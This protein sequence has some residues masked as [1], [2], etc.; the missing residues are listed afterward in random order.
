MNAPEQPKP[1]RP[2]GPPTEVLG[3]STPPKLPWWQRRWGVAT[4]G[5]VCLLV[6]I[7]IG[8][9]SSSSSTKSKPAPT[10]AQL[11]AQAEATKARIHQEAVEKAANERARVANEKKEVREKDAEARATARKEREEA[12]QKHREEQKEKEEAARKKQEETKEYSGG[13][14]KNLG[15]I[16]VETPST[17]HWE[18]GSCANANFIVGNNG[19]DSHQ[20]NV[21]ALK[22][23]SGETY[24]DSGTYNDVEVNTEGE[25]WTIRITPN[26]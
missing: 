20:I 5:V 15:T 22:N 25:S 23:T 12:A 19:G 9:A 6:G 14:A 16:T 10:P 26:E 21:N 4:I 7:G 24:L 11:Q 3:T 8:G 13:G 2:P 18:C 17:L 1:P